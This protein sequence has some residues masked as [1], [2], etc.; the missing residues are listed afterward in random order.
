M[1]DSAAMTSVGSQ[2]WEEHSFVI[3]PLLRLNSSKTQLFKQFMDGN[4][5]ELSRYSLCP[6]AR[7][8][9]GEALLIQ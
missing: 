1:I 6:L 4:P 2:T 8:H 9:A 7:P 3:W 5:K